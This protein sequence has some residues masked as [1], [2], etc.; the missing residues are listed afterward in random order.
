MRRRD[1]I[2]LVGGAVAS[3]PFSARAQQPERMR[4]V[5][6]LLSV[7]SDP[8]QQANQ[9]IFSNTLRGSGWIEGRNITVD[10]RWA[11]GGRL[12]HAEHI[13]VNEQA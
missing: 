1:F 7:E 8:N 12:R 5:G 13:G 3:R 10:Y 4:R 6:V 11:A 2:A 9:A